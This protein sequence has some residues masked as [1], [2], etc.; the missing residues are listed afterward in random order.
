MSSLSG[1]AGLNTEPSLEPNQDEATPQEIRESLAAILTSSVFRN[2]K[3]SRRLLDYLVSCTLEGKE[4]MLKERIIGVHVFERK[5]DYDA[6]NDPIVRVRAA[7]LRKRLA[8]YYTGE[9]AE[10]SFRIEI[11]PGS[12]HPVF[13]PGA[14]QREASDRQESAVVLQPIPEF[15]TALPRPQVP[16]TVVVSAKSIKGLRKYWIWAAIAVCLGAILFIVRSQSRSPID[17]FWEPVQKNSRPV[18]VYLGTNAVYRLSDQFLSKYRSTHHI[19]QEGQEFF[20]DLPPD[21]QIDASDLTRTNGYVMGD[22]AAAAT[23]LTS[24]LSR[25]NKPFELRWDHDISVGDLR[26]GNVVM[27]GAFNN[28]L[29]LR[30]TSKLRFV[31]EGGNRIRDQFD[32]KRVWSEVRDPK[33]NTTEEYALISRLIDPS[34]GALVISAA[35]IGGAGTQAAS[36]FLCNPDAIAGAMD[37][38]PTGWKKMSVQILLHVKVIDGVPNVVNVVSTYFW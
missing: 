6:G 34:S 15:E 10:S 22:D 4:E 29:A 13:I 12:Y 30:M 21:T 11:R 28:E 32:S 25:K 3:Q 37:K 7:D 18:L 16:Q 24:L 20:V 36:S 23:K 8:Q 19:D 26:D 27:I 17:S 5:A 14:S 33:G 35:G 9:G 31:F 1:A 2:S 38:A